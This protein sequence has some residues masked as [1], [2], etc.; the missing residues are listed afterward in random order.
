MKI[1]IEVEVGPTELREFLGL[2]DVATVQQEAL[3]A[4]V[5]KLRSGASS[6][7][8]AV[9][10]LRGMMPEG[11][12]SLSEWQRLIGRALQT[13]RPVTVE[14]TVSPKREDDSGSPTRRASA[15]PR[16][17]RGARKKTS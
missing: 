13:G 2:P 4:V 6:G 7:A 10:I 17:K 5:H 16:K 8:D 11:L 14:T 12:T 9:A 3:D 1:R 15:S